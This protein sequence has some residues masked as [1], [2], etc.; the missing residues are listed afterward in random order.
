MKIT[1]NGNTTD[2]KSKSAVTPSGGG[3]P[4]YATKQTMWTPDP[5]LGHLLYTMRH[6]GPKAPPENDPDYDETE[7]EE[8]FEFLE[9]LL[10]SRQLNSLV[11]AHNVILFCNQEQ[12]PCV[13]NAC[14]ITADVMED[15]RPFALMIEECRELY[16][17]LSAPHVRVRAR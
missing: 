6:V 8:D 14:Q 11:K 17:L 4:I 10:Q 3:R 16:A 2:I 1:M 12:C 5:A 13:S 9:Q 15:I 7:A